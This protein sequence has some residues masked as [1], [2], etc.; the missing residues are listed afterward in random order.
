M[1]EILKPVKVIRR[2]IRAMVFDSGVNS[3]ID[4]VV[5]NRRVFIN[6]RLKYSTRILYIYRTLRIKRR[7]L[8]VN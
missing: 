3:G 6:L 2:D 7:D 8:R 1:H 4:H 5:Q